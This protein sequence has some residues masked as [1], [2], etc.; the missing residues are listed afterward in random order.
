MADIFQKVFGPKLVKENLVKNEN[1]NRLPSP[2]QLQGMIIL[3]GTDKGKKDRRTI[4][5]RK[6]SLSHIIL[7][8][9]CCNFIVDNNPTD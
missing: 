9:S 3:K 1:L 7:M 2:H 6:T 5:V 4:T 8:L